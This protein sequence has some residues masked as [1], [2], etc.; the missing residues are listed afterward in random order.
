MNIQNRWK[1]AVVLCAVFFFCACEGA[2]ITNIVRGEGV[3]DAQGVPIA[4]PAGMFA[5][6]PWYQRPI[7]IPWLN[8]TLPVWFIVAI[9][10]AL[11]VAIAM[12]W[13]TYLRE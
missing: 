4:M 13:R 7:T 12:V 9:A 2:T 3:E 5:P 1:W 11:A 10:F 6:P 8:T